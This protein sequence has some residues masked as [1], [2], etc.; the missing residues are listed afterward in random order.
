M[1]LLIIR[2]SS[3]G[4][5][6]MTVPVVDSLARQYPR[7]DITVLTLTKFAAFPKPSA[8][9]HVRAVDLKPPRRAGEFN[10]W[11]VMSLEPREWVWF[12]TDV[13]HCFA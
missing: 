8:H 6:A 10:V 11:V 2:F 9:A 5:V 12:R 13:V 1:K 3:L 7:L 4:D